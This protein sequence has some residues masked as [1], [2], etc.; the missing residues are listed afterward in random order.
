VKVVID[1]NLVVALFLPLPY[2]EQ[3]RERFLA[4]DRDGSE[5]LAPA[6][7]EYEVNSSLHRAAATGLLAYREA[8]IAVQHALALGVT[9]V[10]PSPRLHERAM[11]WAERL[12]HRRSYDAQYVSLAEQEQAELWTA[13]RRLANGARQIGVGWVHWV[14]ESER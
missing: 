10:S 9:C 13:D 14:G 6:L 8:R 11:R 3:A 7:L 1:A 5:L 4:W 2:S 12:N